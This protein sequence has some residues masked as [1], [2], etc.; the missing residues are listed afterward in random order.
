[1]VI[2]FSFFFL[3]FFLKKSHFLDPIMVNVHTA[4]KIF[5]QLFVYV[6]VF[7]PATKWIA[8]LVFIWTPGYSD[9]QYLSMINVIGSTLQ[10]KADMFFLA[11]YA[12]KHNV[13]FQ[14]GIIS[15]TFIATFIFINTTAHFG[16]LEAKKG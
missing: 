15:S 16:M 12:L 7:D 1:M 2:F 4:Y 14:K 5:N 9:L 13:L 3:F 11:R 8:I 6:P 10:R